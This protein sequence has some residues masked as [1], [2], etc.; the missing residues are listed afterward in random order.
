MGNLQA[1]FGRRADEG[2]SRLTAASMRPILLQDEHSLA[3]SASAADQQAA[4]P[5][6]ENLKLQERLRAS[7][8]V[9]RLE[10]ESAAQRAEIARLQSSGQ[11]ARDSMEQLHRSLQAL[12][13]AHQQL[14]ELLR[15]PKDSV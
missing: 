5:A 7:A 15:L 1:C 10:Q 6:A 12:G 11:N 14:D 9:E 3:P 13:R 4:G 2:D 8:D